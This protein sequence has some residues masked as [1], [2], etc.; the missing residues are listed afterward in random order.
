MAQAG[1]VLGTMQ[2]G[3]WV[4]LGAGRA[5]LCGLVP[6]TGLLPLPARAWLVMEETGPVMALAGSE[7]PVRTGWV[8][9]LGALTTAWLDSLPRL[10]ALAEA[11]ERNRQRLRQ[12]LEAEAA[13]ETRQRMARILG[14]RGPAAPMPV[15]DAAD[16]GL[17]G[18]MALVA[19]AAGLTL[20]RPVRVR[21]ADLDRPADAAA[22]AR[23]SNLRLRRVNLRGDWWRQDLGPLL[24]RQG[25]APVA[26]LPGRQGYRLVGSEGEAEI[27]GAAAAA[28]IGATAWCFVRPF[29]AAEV[30]LWTL[31]GF[32]LSG[33]AADAGMLGLALLVGALLGQAVPL[34]VGLAF[35]LLIPAGEGSALMQLGL[36]LA[37]VAGLG[38]GLRLVQEVARQ[39][40]EIPATGAAHA[41]LWD[42]VLQLPLQALQRYPVGELTARIAASIGLPAAVR[43]FAIMAAGALAMLV[44]S[45]A[46]LLWHHPLAALVALGVTLAQVLAA[47]LAA[48][49]QARAFANGE[50]LGGLADATAFQLVNGVAKLRLAGA[51][52]RG[53][54][55]WAD[56]FAAMRARS[57]RARA[58]AYG[59]DAWLVGSNLLGVVAI[60]AV[61]A[62]LDHPAEGLARAGLSDVLAFIAAYAVHSQAANGLARGL[63]GV[64]MQRP[65]WRFAQP[66][67][68]AAT[69]PA[70]ERSD[71]GRLS[72]GVE[73]VNLDFA[74]P[75][76]S[77]VFRGLSLS[78]A[79]GEFV[80]VTG[81]S[82][83]GKTTLLRL[84]LGL[85]TAQGGGIAYDGQALQTLDAGA[86]RRQIGTVLQHGRL[87]PGTILEAVRGLSEA[88][89]AAIWQAL[90][91]A[92]MAETVAAL[93]MG[94]RTMVTDAS[95]TLSGGQ[96]QRLL[97]AR[98]LVQRPAILLLDEATSAL[99]TATEAAVSQAL[100]GIAATRI[101][102]AH[103]LSTI[104]RADRILFLADGRVA[105][106]GTYTELVAQG[107]GFAR[108]VAAGQ[109]DAAPP[110]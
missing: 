42:R 103:R 45:A 39:R 76:G 15:A 34:A 72:G 68:Q 16:D 84:L 83:C 18:V 13:S 28:G 44:S 106:S 110:N 93:P 20:R 54:R 25:D 94:L 63:L 32:G 11:E 97:I 33:R 56:R 99:D 7:P 2:E 107:G 6:V 92:A 69:E 70:A 96:V 19:R 55:R 73:V 74:Y 50:A 57:V 46:T 82:G 64:W 12:A 95:R 41:A 52:E 89:E 10:R 1:Q 60:Y 91:Q 79:P 58:V 109:G 27:D 59:H 104:R 17:F 47:G 108:L 31:L 86:L 8:A 40:V 101:I 61:I 3:V 21:E 5:A 78:I 85:E 75:G 30:R 80:A 90:H 29:P 62:L 37:A 66:L 36:A 9:A 23:A 4:D 24:G 102:I 43:G 14:D 49:L 88:D 87:P 53:F 67:L 105:E 81:A 35:S 38:H 48:W 98:A 26:L 71:P 65:A 22:I 51:E 100:E 77:P